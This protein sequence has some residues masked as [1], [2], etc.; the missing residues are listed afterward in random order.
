MTDTVVY[1]V[2]PDRTGRRWVVS[3]EGDAAF[4]EE[5]STK[6]EAVRAAEELAQAQVPSVVKVHGP[7]GGTTDEHT[8]EADPLRLPS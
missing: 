2:V 3:R 6:D 8:Y 5:H 7:D 1:H 4:R